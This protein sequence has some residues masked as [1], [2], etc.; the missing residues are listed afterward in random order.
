M[1]SLFGEYWEG[2]GGKKVWKGREKKKRERARETEERVGVGRKDTGSCLFR[3]TGR[4]RKRKR[5]SW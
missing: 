4:G 2:M 5:E 1:E 3:R